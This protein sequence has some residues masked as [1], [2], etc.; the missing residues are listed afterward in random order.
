LE[1][2][3][4]P[5]PRTPHFF[6]FNATQRQGNRKPGSPQRKSSHDLTVAICFEGPNP[7]LPGMHF[8]QIRK[9]KKPTQKG[10]HMPA[11]P[12]RKKVPACPGPN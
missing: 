3:K 7:E 1:A 5:F 8:R 4:K 11:L 10:I 2:Q 12:S 6:T 9:F